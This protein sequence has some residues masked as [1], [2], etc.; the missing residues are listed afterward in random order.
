MECTSCGGCCAS[1]SN[2]SHLMALC[3]WNVAVLISVCNQ[4]VLMAL[5]TH[6]MT[7]STCCTVCTK[8]GNT[9]IKRVTLEVGKGFPVPD[10]GPDDE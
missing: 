10:C 9:G 7:S 3:G 4:L 6:R 2:S 8:K 1:Q 5:T